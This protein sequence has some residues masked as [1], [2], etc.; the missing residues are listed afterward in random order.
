MLSKT[1][2]LSRYSKINS[3][4]AVE[5]LWE[6]IYARFLILANLIMAR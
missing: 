3:S 5:P 1:V 6:D 4:F 2:H